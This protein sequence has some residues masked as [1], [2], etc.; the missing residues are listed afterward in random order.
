MVDAVVVLLCLVTLAIEIATVPRLGLHH[1]TLLLLLLYV[2]GGMA[3]VTAIMI[4]I[5]TRLYGYLNIV[6]LSSTIL[7]LVIA[8]I[9]FYR[10]A[11]FVPGM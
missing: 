11:T 9:S 4:S 7:W 10:V 5:R 2:C 3:I 1:P 6:N 8:G